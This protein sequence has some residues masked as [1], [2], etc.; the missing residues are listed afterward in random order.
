MSWSYL[1]SSGDRRLAGIAN[2][3]LTAGHFSTFAY[4]R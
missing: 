2:V 4:S 3:G 1:P